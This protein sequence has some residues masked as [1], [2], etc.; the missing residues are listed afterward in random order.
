MVG[1]G[2]ITENGSKREMKNRIL[3]ISAAATISACAARG[4]GNQDAPP[5]PPPLPDSV[6]WD[7]D[8]EL[9]PLL[10]RSNFGQRELEASERVEQY[11]GPMT[12]L[13]RL[14]AVADDTTAP[15]VIRINALKL[16]THRVDV[17][18]LIV[19]NNALRSPDERV[20]MEAVSSMEEFLP[21]AEKTA[22]AI[23]AKALRDPN[24]RIQA[25]A[26]ELLS[27]R[28]EKVLR[29][30]IGFATNSELRG[31]ARDLLQTAESRGAPLAP[32][33]SLGTLQRTTANGVTITFRPTQRWP[34]WDAAVGELF[35]RAA[36]EKEPTRVAA[37]VEVVGNVLPAFVAHDSLALVYEANRAIHV[38]W[39]RDHS[40]RKLA[41]GIAP[42]F[43][44]FTSDVIFLREIQDQSLATP[45]D[46]PYR[47]QVIR[48]PITGGAE[49]VV[50]E[51]KT[52]TRND[53]KGNYSPVRWMR[54]RE[55]N[56]RFYLVGDRIDEF[57]LPNPFGN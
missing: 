29:E 45:H 24:P 19:F 55:Q 46:V 37:N 47:Y 36:E 14:S 54:V 44:P 22:T 20:R 17:P 50:G 48:I 5:P 28:N 35:V 11:L 32:V 21:A 57:E 33:D 25:R 31:V 7:G 42:R 53:V 38:H 39:L 1:D 52:T 49:A 56:G 40:D 6:V 10:R 2:G 26:L 30:Y 13:K 3:I 27:D 12:Y 51:I 43:L 9:A 41:D 16:L 23:L 4:G 18:H 15:N 34:Q 8:V